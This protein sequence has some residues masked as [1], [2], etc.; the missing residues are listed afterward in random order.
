MKR[1]WIEDGFGM[2]N[3]VYERCKKK[4]WK[5]SQ[6]CGSGWLRPSRLVLG[7]FHHWQVDEAFLQ[8]R[9]GY[10]PFWPNLLSLW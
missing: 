10:Q 6:N 3:V 9:W 5:G 4:S 8:I 1:G 7:S 2:S